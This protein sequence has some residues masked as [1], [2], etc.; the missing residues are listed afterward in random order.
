M[1]KH[2]PDK[3]GSVGETMRAI[4]EAWAV[5]GNKEKKDEYDGMKKQDIERKKN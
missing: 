5:L 2:Q 1:K 4:N 3:T